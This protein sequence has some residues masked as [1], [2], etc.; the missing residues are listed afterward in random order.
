MII[1]I[2]FAAFFV[3]GQLLNELLY[4]LKEAY[5]CSDTTPLRMPAFFYVSLKIEYK[6]LSLTVNVEYS[7]EAG[8]NFRFFCAEIV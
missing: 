3:P 4:D 1:G 5:R 8:I 6:K 2:N 7:V